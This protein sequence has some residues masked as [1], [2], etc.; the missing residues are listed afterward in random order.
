MESMVSTDVGNRH[1]VGCIVVQHV[2]LH[3]SFL[4]WL[5][6]YSCKYYI[7]SIWISS[8]VFWLIWLK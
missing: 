4:H 1:N 8:V 3:T 2:Q 6:L 5:G 7:G